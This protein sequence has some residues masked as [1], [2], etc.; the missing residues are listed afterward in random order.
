MHRSS[1][2]VVPRTGGALRVVIF[3]VVLVPSSLAWTAAS[4]SCISRATTTTSSSSSSLTQLHM[5]VKAIRPELDLGDL[6]GGRPGAIL[7]SEA[8]LER[9]AEMFREI[10]RDRSLY[11][12]W[13]SDYGELLSDVEAVFDSEEGEDSSKLGEWDISYLKSK[14]DYELDPAKGDDDP[15]ALLP[16]KRY[17]KQIPQDD[18][19]VD[20]GY[21][22]ILGP[23]YP[24]DE[25]TI[26]GTIDSYMVDEESRDERML[27][28]LFQPGDLEIQQNE[29]I[30]AFRKSLDIIEKYTDPFFPE[31]E[32]PR[33]MQPWYGYPE[34]LA[35]PEKNYTNN[36]FTKEAE[37][38]PFDDYHPHKARKLAVQYARAK[39]S[40]W[41][42][43][44][45]S[46]AY[47]TKERAPYERYE[48]LVGTTKP[49]ACNAAQV[50]A[51]GPALKILGSIV[52]LLSIDGNIYRFHYHGLIKNKFGMSCWAQTLLEDCGVTVDSVIF[53]TGF[54]KRDP[55]HDGGSPWYGPY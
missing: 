34:R 32:V 30:R 51:I 14:F 40:E 53:E 55:W 39:N 49:G 1:S 48:T 41:L 22:P 12:E 42:R 36:R 25:R 52:D 6:S 16:N 5:A 2:G 31:Y 13:M 11:P 33:H 24:M 45:T 4:Q 27:T 43:P 23:S 26:V 44:E 19:G 20:I 54:R 3:M 37:I 9:K 50:A 18:D 47:H 8:E 46:L 17:L 29:D 35:Y 10:E 28:P 21:N 7:E 38:S 15:N